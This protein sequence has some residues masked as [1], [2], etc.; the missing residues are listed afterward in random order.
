MMLTVKQLN[1]RRILHEVAKKIKERAT[2]TISQ[3]KDTAY[4]STYFKEE[5]IHAKEI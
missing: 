4:R 3:P 1:E 5:M 2:L